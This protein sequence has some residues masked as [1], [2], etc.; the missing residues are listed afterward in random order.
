MSN[1]KRN[2][3]AA[4]SAVTGTQASDRTV[5]NLAESE[6]RLAEARK[7]RQ[8]VL[9]RKEKSLPKSALKTTKPWM[10]KPQSEPASLNARPA[11][12]P[13][14]APKK[15]DHANLVARTAVDT[16]KA[17]AI[18]A[19]ATLNTYWKKHAPARKPISFLLGTASFGFGITLGLGVLFGSGIIGQS[20]P[21]A[22][23]NAMQSPVT[24][25]SGDRAPQAPAAASASAST[26]PVLDG[27]AS[28]ISLDMLNAPTPVTDASP[29]VVFPVTTN[30]TPL[31]VNASYSLNDPPPPD[32]PL[33]IAT[34]LAESLGYFDAASRPARVFIH[35]PDRVPD[36]T[37]AGYVGQ[38][39]E[40]GFEVAR[41][42]REG[43]TVS[44]THMRYYS[45][46]TATIARA[47]ADE[48][49]IEARDFSG[50][51]RSSDRI[52]VWVAG[53]S[54]HSGQSTA[55]PERTDF[56]TRFLNRWVQAAD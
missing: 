15:T 27:F 53:T 38:I 48:L 44:S 35:A 20:T 9:A 16:V 31:V 45:T 51:A 47:M 52:E 10:E 49:G 26:L 6:R 36:T 24:Q 28:L 56:V 43:F 5:P 22:Q 14:P 12:T 37:L 33:R 30:P 29:A 34:N 55:R 39:E 54:A 13:K 11:G 19:A 7:K 42:G 3:K 23:L 1:V 25:T 18:A 40:T 17:R 4:I 41:I 21:E 2:S 8:A 46:E 32:A 50:S